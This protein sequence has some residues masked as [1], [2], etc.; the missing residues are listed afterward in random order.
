MRVL[1]VDDEP[2]AR[3]VAEAV[4]LSA[5]HEVESAADGERAVALLSRGHVDVLVTDA[6]MPGMSGFELAARVR[7]DAGRYVYVIML[8][9][10]H[11]DDERLAGMQAGVDDYLTK[12]VRPS[13]LTASL[14]AAQRVVELHRRL[15]EQSRVLELEATR[16]ALT[17][18][19]NRRR[20]DN[21]L[22]VLRARSRRYGQRFCL[23]MLDV[24]RFK[25]YND[26]YGHPAGDEALRLVAATMAEALRTGD[27]VYRY[28]GEEFVLLLHDQGLDAGI[29]AVERV[30]QAVRALGLPHGGSEHGV[31][32]VSAGVAESP[33]GDASGPALGL[34]RAADEALFAA[35]QRGR[36]R[37]VAAARCPSEAPELTGE[38]VG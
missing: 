3:M 7:Q 36:D 6:R 31:V 2:T 10:L 32:T 13:V 15:E 28:G 33:D 1:V 18:V 17:G 19:W 9:A 14:I 8:T 21:D 25:A 11:D 35:K 20:L 4:V 22:E 34:L 16:D 23:A 24:D 29:T 27:A 38:S 26:S 5:G 30:R 12:P 37:V